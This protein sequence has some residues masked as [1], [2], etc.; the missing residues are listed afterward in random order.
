V[1]GYYVLYLVH[2][3]N[4]VAYNYGYRAA[5]YP[6]NTPGVAGTTGFECQLG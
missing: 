4:R 1:D 2:F 5:G 3:G 6:M